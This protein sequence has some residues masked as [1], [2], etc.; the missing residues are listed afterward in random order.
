MKLENL[1]DSEGW[2]EPDVGALQFYDVV[3]KKPWGPWEIGH[4]IPCLLL[5]FTEGVAESL[6]PSDGGVLETV[7]F[8]LR[9]TS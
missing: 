1:F 8:D 7:H 4:K 3:F 2:D 6:S 9:T 5:N